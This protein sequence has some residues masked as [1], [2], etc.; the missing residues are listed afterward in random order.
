MHD[1][2][3]NFPFERDD[4]YGFLLRREPSSESLKLIF[5]ASEEERALN[6]RYS[7]RAIQ[8]SKKLLLS[9]SKSVKKQRKETKKIFSER[10]YWMRHQRRME[11]NQ[12]ALSSSVSSDPKRSAHPVKSFYRRKRELIGQQILS[13]QDGL[14]GSHGDLPSP[15]SDSWFGEEGTDLF[16][17]EDSSIPRTNLN[18]GYSSRRQNPF[19]LVE[20]GVDMIGDKIN[21]LKRNSISAASSPA[22]PSV[23][24]FMVP[25]ARHFDHK[26]ISH[27][28]RNASSTELSSPGL[29][30]SDSD[31]SATHTSVTSP[32]VSQ[33]SP[34]LQTMINTSLGDFKELNSVVL[35]HKGKSVHVPEVIPESEEETNS[36]KLQSSYDPRFPSYNNSSGS[37]ELDLTSDEEPQSRLAPPS[38][39]FSQPASAVS[40]SS[41]NQNPASPG[42]RSHSRSSSCLGGSSSIRRIN[43]LL[44]SSPLITSLNHHHNQSL[45]SSLCG[46]A[47]FSAFSSPR[48]YDA[49]QLLNV[50]QHS[51][52]HTV[53]VVD[54]GT[55]LDG[56][57]FS[58]SSLSLPWK[59][60]KLTDDTTPRTS[61]RKTSSSSKRRSC[62]GK[63]RMPQSPKALLPM[64]ATDVLI[65]QQGGFSFFGR[66]KFNE[67][68]R[69]QPWQTIKTVRLY[70]RPGEWDARYLDG[71]SV[72]K[73]TNTS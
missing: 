5:Q 31:S 38:S 4:S 55:N 22:S 14:R 71:V 45:K 61:P 20:R 63:A 21:Q 1:S 30:S 27:M 8:F 7:R 17:V 44:H 64:Y 72:T 34:T 56:Q 57:N 53:V 49:S 26:P 19:S 68:F 15:K 67:R 18:R 70:D 33:A 69:S 2:G 46:N 59:A 9:Q 41:S 13:I 40:V 62:D 35:L 6:D 39:L 10:D 51:S 52:E 42:R 37:E 32:S 50:P 29:S 16:G 43:S 73:V 48:F 58:D 36:F 24:T 28:D 47:S 60:Q 54:C 25:F 66:E 12:R 65:Q 11:R 3:P 23:S